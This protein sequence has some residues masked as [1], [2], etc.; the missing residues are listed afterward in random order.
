MLGWALTFLVVAIIAAF[1]GFG[2]IAVASAGIAKRRFSSSWFCLPSLSS[3][4]FSAADLSP[5]AELSLVDGSPSTF[6]REPF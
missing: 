4:R 3:V 1:F 2:G 5:N 6:E